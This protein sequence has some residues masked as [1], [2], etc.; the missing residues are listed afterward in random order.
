MATTNSETIVGRG[1]YE[2]GEALRMI[3]GHIRVDIQD[4][5]GPSRDGF[6]K[7]VKGR[8]YKTSRGSQFAP[9]VIQ[10]DFPRVGDIE[11]VSFLEL[12]ELHLIAFF[13]DKG[14]SLQTIRLCAGEFAREFDTP[15]PF[16]VEGFAT[17]GNTIFIRL[18]D[19]DPPEGVNTETYLRDLKTS[20]YV[21]EDV[22]QPFLSRIDYARF[23]ASHL[24]PLGKDAGI[25]LDPQRS[26]GQPIIHASRVPTSSVYDA[27]KG[28]DGVSLVAGWF[29]V[30][31]DDVRQAVAYEEAI[32]NAA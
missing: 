17:D 8:K 7:W 1:A 16:A 27:I 23:E 21:M 2:L 26:F 30:T 12:I 19:T 29:G 24:W 25:V 22:A 18:Q 10:R 14:V 9:P 31:E 13:R 3:R 32:R 15:H 5:R 6:R 20:Q 4:F 11:V 28:G